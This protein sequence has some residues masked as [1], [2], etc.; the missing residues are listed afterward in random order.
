MSELSIDILSIYTVSFYV[1]SN[2]SVGF[3]IVVI[4]NDNNVP[5]GA[6][7][8]FVAVCIKIF[9]LRWINLCNTQGNNRIFVVVFRS[10]MN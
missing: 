8:R 1:L 5:I 6:D 9:Y 3:F 2:I 10:S 4:D 7:A